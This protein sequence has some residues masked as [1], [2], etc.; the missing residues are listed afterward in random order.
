T[1]DLLKND[2]ILPEIVSAIRKE[3]K[4]YSEGK[5]VPSWAVRSSAI[6]E[7]SEELSAAG[8]NETFLGCQN[9]EQILKAVT[10]CWASLYTYQSVQ[11]RWQHGLSVVTDMAVVV[12]KMVPA[13][14]AGVL[15]TCHPS[16]SNPSQM[17]VTSN[18]G[19]GEVSHQYNNKLR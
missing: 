12:Q 16:T 10:A 11:Y 3:L 7:D 2:M 9:E 15:F 13:D 14:S 6:G 5:G 17:V 19:I 8:Q 1:V 18:F 4:K